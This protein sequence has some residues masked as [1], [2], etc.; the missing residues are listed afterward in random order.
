MINTIVGTAQSEAAL[1]YFRLSPHHFCTISA[2]F[3]DSTFHSSPHHFANHDFVFTTS[4]RK[5]LGSLRKVAAATAPDKEKVPE[6]VSMS[7]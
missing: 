5:A 4:L 2:P 7:L 6:R 3:H 1:H